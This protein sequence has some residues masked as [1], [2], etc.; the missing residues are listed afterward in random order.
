MT[1]QRTVVRGFLKFTDRWNHEIHQAIEERVLESIRQDS[2]ATGEM[3]LAERQKAI[4]ERRS[5]YFA[6]V[7]TTAN[8]LVAAAALVVALVALVVSSIQLFK[9]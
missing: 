9:A 1:F 6:R 8:L 7:C 5:F 2:P 3:D 4:S